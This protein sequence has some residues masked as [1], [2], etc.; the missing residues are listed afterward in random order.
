MFELSTSSDVG[1]IFD[2]MILSGEYSL[3]MIP[4]GIVPGHR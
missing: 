1:N 4:V 3:T 2:L